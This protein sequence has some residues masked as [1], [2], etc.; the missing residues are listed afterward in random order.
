VK[1]DTEILNEH[2][3]ELFLNGNALFFIESRKQCWSWFRFDTS[4]LMGLKR[5][6]WWGL[7]GSRAVEADAGAGRAMVAG[8]CTVRNQGDGD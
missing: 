6:I 3:A 1:T 2:E 8:I 5:S 4:S 7:G